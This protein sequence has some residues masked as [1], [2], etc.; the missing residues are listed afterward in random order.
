MGVTMAQ[1]SS[2]RNGSIKENKDIDAVRELMVLARCSRSSGKVVRPMARRKGR[3][4][5]QKAAGR[6]ETRLD[7]DIRSLKRLSRLIGGLS[8]DAKRLLKAHLA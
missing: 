6:A 2:E 1:A 8:P 3:K 7:R 5:L 4:G